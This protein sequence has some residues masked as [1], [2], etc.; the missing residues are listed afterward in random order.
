M[1][2]ISQLLLVT[3]VL[4]SVV[5]SITCYKGFRIIRGQAIGTETEECENETAYCYNMTAEAA[6]ILNIMKAGCSTYRCMFSAN[7]CRSITFQG[8]PVSFCCCNEYDLCNYS[9]KNL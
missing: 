4:V 7:T 8:V 9:G 6:L 2:K 3:T 1:N 5:Y